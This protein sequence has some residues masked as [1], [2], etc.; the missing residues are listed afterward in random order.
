MSYTPTY[1]SRFRS[2]GAPEVILFFPA[3]PDGPMER[4]PWSWNQSPLGVERM[5]VLER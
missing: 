3:P 4:G 5:H 2:C 1:A